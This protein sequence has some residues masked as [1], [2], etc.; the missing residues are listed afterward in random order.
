[1]S[2]QII[3][4]SAVPSLPAVSAPDFLA[5]LKSLLDVREGQTRNTEERFVTVADLEAIGITA[6]DIQ[7][8]VNRI[9][10][11]DKYDEFAPHPPTNF[12]I[13]NDFLSHT[14]TWENPIDDDLYSIEVWRGETQNR[15]NA[16]LV[17]VVTA[18]VETVTLVGVLPT[19]NYYYWIRAVDTSDNYSEWC[20]NDQ[21]GGAIVQSDLAGATAKILG[22]LNSSITES[23]LYAELQ[24]RIGLIDASPSVVGSVSQRVSNEAAARAAA[25]ATEAT[26]R[27]LAVAAVQQQVDLL[28]GALDPEG[29][30]AAL[31]AIVN[32]ESTARIDGDAAEATNRSLLAS[33]LRGDSTST[34]IALLSSGLLYNEKV[35]RTNADLSIA[36]DVSGLQVA[37]GQNT[38]D[39]LTE[40]TAR[41]TAVSGEATQRQLL[42]TRLLGSYTGND[43]AQL[44]SGLLF[45][46][47]T[48]RVNADGVVVQSVE[49]L[50]SIVGP[51]LA[52]LKTHSEVINGMAAN[53]YLK[54]DVNGYVAG[55]GLYNSGVDSS[56]IISADKF[57]VVKPGANP[58]QAGAVP[59]VVG[60]VNNV[61]TVGINGNLI[62]DGTIVAKAIAAN[63]ITAD[64]MAA[65][66]ILANSIGANQITAVKI[67]ANQII[68]QAANIANAVINDAHIANLSASK[69]N[70]GSLNAYLI[71]SGS[72]NASLI[73]TGTL[74]ADR[75]QAGTLNAGLISQNGISLDKIVSGV[76]ISAGGGALSMWIPGGG[77]RT[78][79]FIKYKS[80]ALGSHHSGDT[81]YN[82]VARITINYGYGSEVIYHEG[83]A[84][85]TVIYMLPGG[86][87][88]VTVAAALNIGTLSGYNNAVP[89]FV[90]EMTY[91]MFK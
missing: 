52:S 2:L 20:P 16:L 65:D 44:T 66:S 41:A 11:L 22:Y 63:V 60:N 38:A 31:V 48:A 90:C 26:N 6:L 45:S 50:Q 85:N 46:E 75:I 18:P 10:E 21:Q 91:M 78:L 49:T 43:I 14:L 54:T 23:D 61:S 19:L 88:S 36:Y 30:Y 5:K 73:T 28:A 56:F 76:V 13:V 89:D 27:Q 9:P 74:N 69:I 86:G 34:D 17:A 7:N 62:V 1:M 70:T 15:N 33:Q 37:V 77:S 51:K 25:I 59:F 42:A 29:D 67:G 83:Y 35:A 87:V 82:N 81:T 72:I 57:A 8:K 12:V 3:R 47:R 80:S 68:T 40:S 64:K 24:T 55:F 84:T 79:L 32:E 4:Q 71:T 58:N 39:I 53:Y